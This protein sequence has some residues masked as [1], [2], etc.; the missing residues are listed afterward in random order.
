MV[1]KITCINREMLKWARA[2]AGDIKTAEFQ[3]LYDKV[4]KWEAGTDSPT[5]AQ[6]E[7]LS[8][9]YRRPL[10]MFFFSTKPKI[11]GIEAEF[12]SMSAKSIRALSYKVVRIINEAYAMQMNIKELD[13]SKIDSQKNIHVRLQ[14][15]DEKDLVDQARLFLDIPI[16]KQLN[17]KQIKSMLEVWRD[18][19]YENGIYVFKDAFH[20]TSISGFCIYDFTYPIIVLN[21]SMSVSRQIFTLFHELYHLICQ[22]GGVDKIDDEDIN[23]FD[24]A[25]KNIE[26]SCNKFAAEF[27]I[28]TA[29]LLQQVS[30]KPITYE[31]VE[32][33]ADLFNV[34]RE[35]M[36]LKLI[37][38]GKADW[39]L[40]NTNISSIQ[41]DLFRAKPKKS[42][43]NPINTLLSYLGR[44]YVN[45]A[46]TAYHENR[47]D[48][49]QLASYMNTSV[50]NLPLLEKA[51]GARD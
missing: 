26:E 30:H 49:F 18:T 35:A 2:N 50:L 1:E 14:A 46:F 22:T 5:Y 36:I 3:K 33:L 31:R 17:T 29:V 40:Y 15:V 6:L 19:F 47:I 23:T 4:L 20:D 16:E 42:G 11:H 45:L 28:P 37:E 27:L 43:G 25:Q 32:E 41:A 39:S 48:T 44:N 51:W 21:N 24:T 10:A 13:D 12:R 38:L 34:S 8:N 7:A 9:I